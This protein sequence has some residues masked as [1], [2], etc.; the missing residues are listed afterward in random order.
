MGGDNGIIIDKLWEKIIRKNAKT[1]K[2]PLYKERFFHHI[3]YHPYCRF[4]E[5]I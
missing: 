5:S 1:K 4:N 3:G 2:Q